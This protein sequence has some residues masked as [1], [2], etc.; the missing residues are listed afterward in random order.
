MRQSVRIKNVE[1][2]NEEK[3]K[4]KEKKIYI[5]MKM[6]KKGMLDFFL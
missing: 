1:E 6:S 2:I 3:K 4:V 5:H